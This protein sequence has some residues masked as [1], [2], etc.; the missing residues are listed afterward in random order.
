[1]S[2]CRCTPNV[3]PPT[4]PTPTTACTRA[5]SGRRRRFPC[6]YSRLQ[7]SD[8]SAASAE[9]RVRR[10]GLVPHGLLLEAAVPAGSRR[11]ACLRCMTA[12]CR[13][14]RAPS[15]LPPPLLPRRPHRHRPCRCPR[16][17]H[18]QLLLQLVPPQRQHQ[19]QHQRQHQRQHHR[20]R[21]LQHQR[22]HQRQHQWQHQHLAPSMLWLQVVLRVM[23]QTTLRRQQRL[24]QRWPL[25][26]SN[27]V[28]QCARSSTRLLVARVRCAATRTRTQQRR[29]V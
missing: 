17:H 1:M 13:R 3:S 28:A 19:P 21:Q 12:V 23:L 27:G 9:A 16:R 11:I 4:A 25:R 24:R 10:R 15:V 26:R 7:P 18:R 29:Q 6:G 5:A 14:M 2:G 8:A 22:Q 20:Q